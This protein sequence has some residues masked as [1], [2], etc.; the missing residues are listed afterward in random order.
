VLAVVIPNVVGVKV[1]NARKLVDCTNNVLTFQMACPNLPPYQFLLGV[2]PEDNGFTFQ[3]DL[4]IRQGAKLIVHFPIASSDLTPCNWLHQTSLDGYI[5]AWSRTN[6]S[7]RLSDLLQSGQTYDVQVTFAKRPP[8][9]SS[10]WLASMK[11]A[12]W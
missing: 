11:K 5:L 12:R 4:T 3:G 6:Q 7:E 1:P 2:A 10:L 9:H 8:Q